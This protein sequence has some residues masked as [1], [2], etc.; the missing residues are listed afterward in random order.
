M[1]FK[2]PS[3]EVGMKCSWL[4]LPLAVRFEHVR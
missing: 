4:E 3:G 1:L 2:L